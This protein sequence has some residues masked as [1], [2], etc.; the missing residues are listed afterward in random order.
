[1][2]PWLMLDE[3]EMMWT[4][5]IVT[6]FKVFRSFYYEF[7]VPSSRHIILVIQLENYSQ[8]KTTDQCREEQQMN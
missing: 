1:M 7:V 4:K 2:V 3:F 5:E 8:N 6:F